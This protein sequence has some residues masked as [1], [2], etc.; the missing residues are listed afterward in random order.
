MKE[1]KVTAIY[2]N[3][4]KND[5]VT[6][7]QVISLHDVY[8]Y[9]TECTELAK[10]SK[11]EMR[12]LQNNTSGVRLKKNAVLNGQSVNYFDYWNGL[13]FVDIDC[14]NHWSLEDNKSYIK[15][16]HHD[17]SSFSWYLWTTTSASGNG[18][19]IVCYFP[20]RFHT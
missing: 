12:V 19:H 1:I 11:A 5:T 4:V 2:S 3:Y 8:I 15:T 17:L 9:Q 14:K 13:V 20:S 10:L 6:N 7:S 16:L 18:I